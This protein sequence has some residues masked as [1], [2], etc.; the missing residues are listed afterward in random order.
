M[1]DMQCDFTGRE[2]PLNVLCNLRARSMARFYVPYE[3]Y[4]QKS[5]IRHVYI[6]Q[7][8][9]KVHSYVHADSKRRSAGARISSLISET[10]SSRGPP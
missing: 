9:L 1:S 5:M 2:P 10:A 4:H 6:P 8:F 3:S 7:R